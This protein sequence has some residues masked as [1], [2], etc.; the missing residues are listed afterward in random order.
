[1]AKKGYQSKAKKDNPAGQDFHFLNEFLQGKNGIIFFALNTQYQYQSFSADHAATMKKIWGVSIEKGM[2]MLDLILS[3]AD[4]TKAKRNF[5]RALRGS[6][7]TKVKQYGDSGLYRTYYEDRYG[8]IRN[9]KEKITGLFVV[10]TDVTVHTKAGKD[11]K[12]FS[13]LLSSSLESVDEG[14]LVV[15][16]KAGI[17]FHN[18]KFLDLWGIHSALSK[19]TDDEELINFVLAKIADSEKFIERVKYLYSNPELESQDQIWL[20]DGRIFNRVSKP[21]FLGKKIIGRVWSFRDV[22]V[23]INQ[24]RSLVEWKTRHELVVASFGRVVYD[25][26]IVSG[27]IIWSGNIAQVLGYEAH[28]M[29]NIDQWGD[30]I[31]PDDRPEAF[32]LLEEAQITLSKY[33]VAYRFKTKNGS[34]VWMRDNGF[35]VVGN[36][37][38]AENMLG[39]M[40]DTS[41]QVQS[42]KEIKQLAEGKLAAE[43]QINDLEL[44]Y[45]ALF[46]SAP[47]SIL[48]L[49]VEDDPGKIIS[50]NQAAAATLGYSMEEFLQLNIKG[51]DIKR[52]HSLSY[53]ERV[54][55][56]AQLG[57]QSFEVSHRHKDGYAVPLDVVASPIEIS[58]KKVMLAIERGI[59]SRKKAESEIQSQFKFIESLVKAM[60]NVV[61]VFDLQTSKVVYGSQ[62]LSAAFDLT[63]E[64][65][66]G[67]CLDTIQKL[68]HPDDARNLPAWT[69]QWKTIKDGEVLETQY[70]IL[71]KTGGVRT[72]RSHETVFMRDAE[73][74]VKQYLGTAIDITERIKFE[75]SLIE[76]ESRF[77]ALH[78]ASFGGIAIHD[79]GVIVECNKAMS[80]MTGYTYKELIGFNGLNLFALEDQPMIIQKIKTQE[81]T[82]YDATGIR[83]DGS[84]FNAE[85][86]GKAVPYKGRILRVTEIRDITERKQAAEK[87]LEQNTRLQAIAE[88]LK[89]RNEQLDEFTQI[90]SHN[91][92]APAGNIISLAEF[93]QTAQQQTERD[94]IMGMLKNSG[95]NILA[96]L[97]E[98]NDVLKIQQ[99]KNIERQE[100]RFE[101]VF[102]RVCNM[103]NSQIAH[104]N[105][106]VEHDFALAPTIMYPNI[107]LESILLNLLSNAIKYKHPERAPQIKIRTYQSNDRVVLEV[108]DNGLGV[109]LTR[110]GH[111]IFKMRKTFHNHPDSRGIGLFMIKNQIE[112]LKGQ[113]SIESIENIGSTF[114]V[115]F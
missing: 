57:R 62:N 69:K 72:F 18:Q 24:E 30:L 46:E 42:E 26:H 64:E 94:E 4:R 112:A 27:R 102:Q 8:P 36:D 6:T 63:T 11:A 68:L 100:L 34:Y 45:K 16:G 19:E 110:Y 99:N 85:V 2:N 89:F 17:V 61:Y 52:D 39:E 10:V 48:I 109:N 7:F 13:S 90:V 84:V 40:T 38:M 91:L 3:K 92:R 71:R 79:K 96:T 53:E 47:D 95:D 113:I 105:A 98:L 67:A 75:E 49:D 108:S 103:L 9:P 60:P 87:I 21:H 81:E 80:E 25:Y 93:L 20:R 37:G 41:K 5:D 35:F 56:I 32:R 54:S 59:T 51:I 23:G 22:T 101:E 55:Q 76:S 88:D 44:T 107:Y 115:L 83:K 114:R 12:H 58:G 31:H 14:I 70:R 29:G 104:S 65:M 74:R 50:A 106:I 78:E 33:S 86:H 73:G 1:M 77:S 43:K 66:A 82:P 15:D 111:Q 97:S 28:E